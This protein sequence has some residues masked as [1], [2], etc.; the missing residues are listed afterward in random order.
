MKQYEREEQI[1]KLFDEKKKPLSNAEIEKELKFTG[2]STFTK[3]LVYYRYLERDEENKTFKRT[4]KKY[5]LTQRA[6]ETDS[7][8]EKNYEM[9]LNKVFTGSF[10]YHNLGHE[11]INFMKDQDGNRYNINNR[12]TRDLVLTATWISTEEVVTTTSVNTPLV[13]GIIIASLAGLV[14]IADIT[15]I[16]IFKKK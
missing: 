5:N 12:V 3:K 10:L 9:V 8:E 1:I 4:R 2:A 7:E 16:F 6:Q 14:I 13:V 15:L 11:L